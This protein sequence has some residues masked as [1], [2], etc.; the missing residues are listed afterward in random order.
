[1]DNTNCK[2]PRIVGDN[3]GESCA[4]CGEQLRGF[5]YGGWFGRN[6]TGTATCIHLWAPLGDS[7]QMVCVYCEGWKDNETA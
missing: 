4:D 3:Y 5:G 1:M 6:L 2:H 7:D